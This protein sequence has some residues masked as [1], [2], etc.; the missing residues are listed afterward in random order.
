MRNDPIKE[1]CGKIKISWTTAF[2][3]MRMIEI[4]LKKNSYWLIQFALENLW[5][6]F[7]KD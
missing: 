7:E 5:M 2:W 1:N 4:M 3:K 6:I